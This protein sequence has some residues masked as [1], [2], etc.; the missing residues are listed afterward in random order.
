MCVHIFIKLNQ[1][2]NKYEMRIFKYLQ[3]NYIY[4][5]FQKYLF[6]N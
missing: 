4:N 3:K 2:K 5:L 1:I 6:T